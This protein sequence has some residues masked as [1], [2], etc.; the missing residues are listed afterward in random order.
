MREG[1]IVDALLWLEAVGLVTRE[2]EGP[3]D[4]YRLRV[5]L[6][7]QWIALQFG[8]IASTTRRAG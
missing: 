1:A 3:L 4:R 2:A 8:S 5:P 6:L 7:A